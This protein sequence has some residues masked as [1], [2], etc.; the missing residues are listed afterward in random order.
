MVRHID[1][2]ILVWHIAE[3]EAR[4]LGSRQIEPPHLF[5]GLLKIV[6]IDLEKI[7]AK[8]STLDVPGI[9]GEV[10]ALELA[11][12]E[13]DLDTT[14]IRRRFRRYLKKG[15][16]I[17]ASDRLRR[18]QKARATF[19][20]AEAMAEEAGGNVHPMHL[21]VALLQQQDPSIESIL[22][23]AEC[24]PT[25]LRRYLEAQLPKLNALG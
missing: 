18:S 10:Q 7:L 25:E 24:F 4:A 3:V 5:L 22:E 11:F 13:Y 15:D 17:E 19:A 2:L 9:A 23:E 14:R 21:A 8:A 6:D 20:R 12:G 16:P 1:S